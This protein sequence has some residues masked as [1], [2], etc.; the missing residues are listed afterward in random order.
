MHVECGQCQGPLLALTPLLLPQT[1]S[2]IPH[3]PAT[4]CPHLHQNPVYE[5][6]HL[7]PH[8]K[9]IVAV[10]VVGMFWDC[11]NRKYEFCTPMLWR[12]TQQQHHKKQAE[13]QPAPAPTS[14]FQPH[15]A[16]HLRPA[17][18]EMRPALQCSRCSLECRSSRSNLPTTTS[19]TSKRHGQHVISLAVGV[20]AWMTQCMATC[21]TKA[22]QARL[23]SATEQMPCKPLNAS[24]GTACNHMDFIHGQKR[25]A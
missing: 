13:L 12:L 4:V 2:P 3:S 21:M 19:V 9:C 11:T 14:V 24:S 20:R 22:A 25:H 18:L 8:S 15:P 16:Y 7:Q 5:C 6:V 10:L 17:Q 23:H 1:K